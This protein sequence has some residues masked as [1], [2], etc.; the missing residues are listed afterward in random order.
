MNEIKVLFL[1]PDCFFLVSVSEDAMSAFQRR[2]LPFRDV[3]DSSFD[4]VVDVGYLSTAAAVELIQRRIVGMRVP[5]I[6]LCHCMSGGLARDLIRAARDVV[7]LNSRDPNGR[8]LAQIARV[9]VA[10]D[11]AVKANAAMI[12]CRRLRPGPGVDVVLS[13]LEEAAT[14]QWTAPDLLDW[15]RRSASK[16]KALGLWRIANLGGEAGTAAAVGLAKEFVAFS[17]FS[18]TLLELFAT[19]RPAQFWAGIA[20]KAGAC[21]IDELVKARQAFTID[22]CLAWKGIVRFRRNAGGFAKAP[23]F[24]RLTPIANERGPR[25]SALGVGVLDRLSAG[26]H[27]GRAN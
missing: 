24:P 25:L 5:F 19:E 6:L 23:P 14:K 11:I 22:P 26:A 2:G 20:P 3:F 7:T 4:D 13:W 12:A 27:D 8:D 17:L 15:L 16:L 18:A 1:I 9:M 10:D 21:P